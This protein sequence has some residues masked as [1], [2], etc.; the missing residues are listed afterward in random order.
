MLAQSA[1]KH[2]LPADRRPKREIRK[3]LSQEED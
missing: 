3:K 1:T 2:A